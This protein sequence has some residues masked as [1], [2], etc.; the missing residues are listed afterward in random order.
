MKP[1]ILKVTETKS[2][3]IDA[4]GAVLNVSV[5]GENMVF[6]NAAY[7]KSIEVKKIVDSILK[8]SNA[9]KI[10]IVGVRI[11]SETGWLNKSTKGSYQIL[12]EVTELDTLNKVFTAMVGHKN[13]KLHG[14]EWKYNEDATK[15]NLITEAMIAA[16]IKA[17][18]MTNAIGLKI[19]GVISCS[20]SYDVPNTNISIQ[21][22]SDNV[23]SELS[24]RSRRSVHN[25]NLGTE[26]RGRKK[27]A[28]VATVEFYV[29]NEIA[30]QGDAPE[31]ATIADSA[32]QP[33]IPPAR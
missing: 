15:N 5:S 25:V 4:I 33:S 17:E 12:L 22:N 8:I 3:D 16:K 20:D 18:L 26:I 7:E 10:N 30:Q 24:T 1:G 6:G 14:I 21:D 19:G 9:I 13:I 32:S 11:E 29:I 28:A 27:I 23:L 31:P 2:S